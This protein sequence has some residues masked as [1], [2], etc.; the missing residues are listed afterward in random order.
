MQLPTAKSVWDLTGSVKT[1][2]FLV[3]Q[4]A[5]D[6]TNAKILSADLPLTFN[7]GTAKI[8]FDFTQENTWIGKQIF[9]EV[10]INNGAIDGTVIGGAAPADGSFTHVFVKDADGNNNFVIGASAAEG[11][12][13]AKLYTDANNEIV[14][15]GN[16]GVA[17]KYGAVSV[18]DDQPGAYAL[19][20]PTRGAGMFYNES[21]NSWLVGTGKYDMS[22]GAI[23]MSNAVDHASFTIFNAGSLVFNANETGNVTANGIFTGSTFRTTPGDFVVGSSLGTAYININDGAQAVVEMGRAAGAGTN[24]GMKFN[25][26]TT[27]EG[28]A[29]IGATQTGTWGVQVGDLA[30]QKGVIMNYATGAAHEARI[31]VADGD[32]LN[33]AFLVDADG[34]L[35]AQKVSINNWALPTDKGVNNGFVLG[36]NSVTG[37][38]TWVDPTTLPITESDPIFS[39]W[40]KSTGIVITKSQVSDFPTVV[41]AFTN[42][43]NYITNAQETD[44]VFTAW[45]KTTGISILSNQ[46]TDFVA[47]VNAAEI[48]PVFTAWDKSTGITITR[49]QISDFPVV[50]NGLNET[51]VGQFQL[52]GTLITPTTITTDATNTLTIAGDGD[53]TVAGSVLAQDGL[54]VTGSALE[55]GSNFSVTQ[56][57]NLGATTGDF[58]GNV[59]SGATMKAVDGEFTNS[60]NVTSTATIGSGLLVGSGAGFA[61]IDGTLD[62]LDVLNMNSNVIK[63][64]T[65]PVDNQDVATKFYV[66]NAAGPLK[67][68]PFLVFEAPTN[69]TNARI[70]NATT[71]LAFDA[72]T[73]NLAIDFTQANTWIGKQTF[74]EVDVNSGL[75]DGTVIGGSVPADGSFTHVF[76]KDAD[77]N[78]NFVI[79]A[80]AAEGCGW[81]K[82]Y[83]DANNEIVILGN[84]GAATKYGAVSVTDDQPGAYALGLP[85]RG[86]GMFYNESVNSWLV[87]TGKYDMSIGAI[88]MSDAVNHASFTIYN[89]GSAVFNADETERFQP[90]QLHLQAIFLQTIYLVQ[91][92]ATKLQQQSRQ[93]WVQPLH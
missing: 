44:Q 36:I 16:T 52:G 51:T 1:E 14:I 37:Q 12:G 55:V 4:A 5:A 50:N 33:P 74:N 46:V 56:A 53:F 20:L 41:S 64:V 86:A 82:L 68:E 39:A 80:S 59:E 89:G 88:A 13:W 78:N 38:A 93:N 42:D 11:C 22:I 63:N 66:D 24:Y 61:I 76:V 72:A 8:G 43:A 6:L 79:G 85:T 60:L 77:G 19:G 29:S 26:R 54:T 65:D 73:A 57:G 10:D 21:V 34:E 71:P 92:P 28:R 25:D 58:S 2:P 15:L 32:L 23:A 27:G 47:A 75:I 83:T 17:T 91:I 45:D 40:D 30:T 49:S 3:Y 84:T 67:A 48:D 69:L 90:Q 87:G 81:A 62:V 7:A 35:T 18:T 9:N 31:I 70:F